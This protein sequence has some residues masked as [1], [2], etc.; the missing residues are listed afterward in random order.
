[1]N[2]KAVHTS[3]ADN[4]LDVRTG[5]IGTDKVILSALFLFFYILK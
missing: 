2:G 1:M 5:N 4:K 3:R